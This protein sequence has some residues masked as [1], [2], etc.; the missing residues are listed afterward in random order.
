MIDEIQDDAASEEGAS[1]EESSSSSEQEQ[2]V[3][4]NRFNEVYGKNKE[5]EK[6]LA[7]LKAP[8]PSSEGISEEDKKLEDKIKSVNDKIAKDKETASVE[9]QKQFDKDVDDSLTVYTD[10]DRDDFKKFIEEK[11]DQYHIDS[12]EGAMAI[13][14]DINKMAE[15]TEEQAIRRL[16]EKPSLPRNEG[17]PM[18]GV[19]HDDSNKTIEEIAEEAATESASKK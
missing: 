7:D 2:T 16:S 5:L 13:Y 10:V 3:P 4:I 1:A 17:T 14:R 12:V 15:E 6:E 8:K 18:A 19:S 11:S 9:E